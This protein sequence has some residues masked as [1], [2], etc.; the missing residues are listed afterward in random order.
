MY[1]SDW[2]VSELSHAYP[3][4][5]G[6]IDEVVAGASEEELRNLYRTTAIR[7]YRLTS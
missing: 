5:V 4:W 7:T 1:G 3:A 6:I 2:T